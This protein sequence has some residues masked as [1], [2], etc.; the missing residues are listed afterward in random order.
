MVRTWQTR[1]VPDDNPYRA[2][3][4]VDDLIASLEDPDLPHAV[5]GDIAR[6]ALE[7]SRV[8]IREDRPVDTVATARDLVAA[9]RRSRIQPVINCT[10]VLLHT[11]LGRATLSPAAAQAMHSAAVTYSNAEIRLSDGSRGGRGGRTQQLLTTLTGAEEAF[12]VNNNASALLLVLAAL[13]GGDA[14]PVARG[15][16]IEIGGSYRLPAVMDASGA[17]LIEVGTT[18]RTRAGDYV[19]ALQLHDCGAVLK[20]HPS[21]YRVEG[22]TEEAS[23][24]E[25]AEIAANQAV[26]LIH[27]VGSGLLDANARWLGP[28]LPAWLR[29]EPA[30]TQSLQAGADVVTFSGDKLLGGPQAGIIVGRAD[31]VEKIRA[32]PLARALRTSVMIDAALA[33]TLDSYASDSVEDIPFWRLARLTEDDLSPRLTA[34]AKAV[35]G[36]LRE[37]ASVIGAGSVPGTGI[38][39]TQIVLEDA[40]DL[41]EPLLRASRPVA[42]RRVDGDLVIDLRAVDPDDDGVVVA[43]VASCR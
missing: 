39:T 14:V 37:G 27:D 12:V 23:V 1:A 5:L 34:V 18:N 20:V 22:F 9:A 29:G 17:R 43:M 7:I 33:A 32:H 3:P 19:T 13:A 42:A 30:V 21:N 36:T 35:G 10:G 16:L 15:E 24:E 11:N 28:T 2:L 41:Y 4:A 25:L 8:S 40:D 6:D 26:P 38:P 31:L